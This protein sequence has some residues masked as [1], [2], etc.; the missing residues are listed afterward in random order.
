MNSFPNGIKNAC[1]VCHPVF[2]IF[3]SLLMTHERPNMAATFWERH[4]RERKGNVLF[5]VPLNT[6][7]L[8]LYGIRHMVKDHS[9]SEKGN[10][11]PPLHRIFFPISSK[12]S[13]ITPSIDRIAHTTAFVFTH[14]VEHWLEREIAQWVLQKGSI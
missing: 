4:K 13:F 14:V 6:F 8:R 7:Y 12:S 1:Q 11:L 9:D 3:I 2:A 5:H 10:L